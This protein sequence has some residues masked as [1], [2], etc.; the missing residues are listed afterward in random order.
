M[1]T[2]LQIQIEK[3]NE[4]FDASEEELKRMRKR[5]IDETWR[6]YTDTGLLKQ[7]LKNL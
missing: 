7:E 5:M 6:L 3:I 1:K 4:K 2:K